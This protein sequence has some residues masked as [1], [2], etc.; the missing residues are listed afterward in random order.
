MER[1]AMDASQGESENKDDEELEAS[2][3]RSSEER[4]FSKETRRRQCEWK[5]Q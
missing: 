2:L 4:M 5:K 3:K 1:L